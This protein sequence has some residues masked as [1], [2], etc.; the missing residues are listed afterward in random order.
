MDGRVFRRTCREIN[1]DNSPSAG[2]GVSKRS[3]GVA[4]PSST[5]V[6]ALHTLWVYYRFCLGHRQL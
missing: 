5:V 1:L 6:I 2:F 4:V 3:D